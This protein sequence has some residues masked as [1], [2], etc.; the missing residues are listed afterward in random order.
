M[1]YPRDF[2]DR[3]VAPERPGTCFL[4]MPFADTFAPVHRAIVRALESADGGFRCRRADEFF[5]GHQVMEDILREI[6]TSELI[7]ADVTGRNPNVFYELGI[8][9]MVKSAARVLLITQ[10]VDD[11]PFDL[12]AYRH[13]VYTHSQRGL[14]KLRSDLIIAARGLTSAVDR[15]NLSVNAFHETAASFPGTDRCLYSV[16]ASQLMP[17]RDF[18]K[19]M[20]QVNKHVVNK[21]VQMVLSDTLGLTIGETIALVKSL[22]FR[23][24]LDAVDRDAASFSIVRYSERPS[25]KS[26][27]RRPSNK[28]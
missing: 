9:H 21:P 17:G 24:R 13:I 26:S 18:A 22:P 14:E 1:T 3:P 8:A 5:G 4:V 27:R 16:R 19:C 15:F 6:G 2:F 7:V 25:P 20:I 10:R 12:R 23:I 28:R 11:I